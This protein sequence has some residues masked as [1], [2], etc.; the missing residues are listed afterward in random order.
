MNFNGRGG[1]IWTSTPPVTRHLIVINLLIWVVEAL[2][3]SLGARIVELFG[4]HYIGASAFNPVQLVTS[5]FVHS[6]STMMHV[7]FNMFTLWMFGRL[8]ER[9]WGTKRFLIYYF[10]CGVGACVVQE[11]VWALTWEHDMYSALGRLN[12]MTADS[13]RSMF[14][15]ATGEDLMMVKRVTEQFQSQMVTIGASG[16]VFGILLGFAFVFPNMPMYLFFIPVPIK[17][18]YMVAGYAV[19]E[20]FLGVANMQGDSV[21][22]FAHLGGLIFGFLILLW[23]KKTGKL[24][25]GVF[26]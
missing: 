21:A 17:A 9:V 23:W 19:L 7:L 15:N 3:P 22:H 8:L 14:S 5:L 13:V 4:L 1:N 11:G 6:P 2:V 12:G 26:Y 18:K 10:V 16:A 20:F 24:G 25:G